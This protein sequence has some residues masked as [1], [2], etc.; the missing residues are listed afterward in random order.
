MP[1][2]ASS[3]TGR[4]LTTRILAEPEELGEL[5]GQWDALA[6]QSERPFVAPAWALSWWETLRPDSAELRLV[7]VLDGDSLVG[8]VPLYC[9]KRAYAPLG[10]GMAPVEPLARVG[11]ERQ[12][13]EAAQTA[14]AEASPRPATVEVEMHRSSP[15]WAGLLGGS[16][17]GGRGAGRWTRLEA[18]VP[19]IDLGEGFEEWL[20]AKSSRFRRE[21]K[22]RRRKLEEAGGSFR[23][24][25]AESLERD[26]ATFMRL[27]RQRRAGQG[28]TSLSDDGV[29]RMLVAVGGKLLDS[30]RFRLLSI[31]LDGEPIAARLLL[32]AGREVSAWNSGFDEA[33]SKLS[34]SMLSI[35]E[36]LRDASERGERTMSLGPGGQEY[37]YR[38]SN[39]EDTL[40]SH[41]LIVPGAGYP[42]ARLRLVPSQIR[43]GVSGRLSAG[44]KRRLRG[45]IR[46]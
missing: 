28:G 45:L 10:G 7:V 9:S 44:T 1:A 30:G 11:L 31:D 6:M 4:P 26:V 41:V 2:G 37:K 8:I 22:R 3:Q 38:L 39:W 32:A 40:C 25:T 34:P 15:D 16:W 23:F 17:L 21:M 29:E 13:A 19:R 14:L 43:V 27:H 35:L 33:H 12:V 18:P 46:R 42:L 20:G 24:A 5:W 36:A